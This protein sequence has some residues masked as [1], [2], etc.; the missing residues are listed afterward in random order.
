MTNEFLSFLNK[1]HIILYNVTFRFELSQDDVNYHVY[2]DGVE[3]TSKP[4][5]Y[6]HHFADKMR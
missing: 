3:D 6:Y 4:I 2:A 5:K 1:Y